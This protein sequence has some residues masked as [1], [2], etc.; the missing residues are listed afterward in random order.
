MPSPI[1]PRLQSAKLSPVDFMSPTTCSLFDSPALKRLEIGLN[2]ISQEGE[3]GR[4]LPHLA[5]QATTT[6]AWNLQSLHY[7]GPTD[8]SLF[9]HIAKLAS[10]TSVTLYPK[11]RLDPRAQERIVAW[12]SGFA[13]KRTWQSNWV[14]FPVVIQQ[15]LANVGGPH[16][17]GEI[18]RGLDQIEQWYIGEGWYTDGAGRSFDYTQPGRCT[19]TPSCGPGCPLTG[20]AVTAIGSGCASS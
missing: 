20:N 18:D 1:F 4:L 5:L 6:S 13:G 8:E 19:C 2:N 15:F 3:P 9:P 17:T 7:A 12:L 10:L 11:D 14:L 16:D